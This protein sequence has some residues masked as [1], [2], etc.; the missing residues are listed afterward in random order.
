MI[1]A[2]THGSGQVEIEHEEPKSEEGRGK[3]E[4]RLLKIQALAALEKMH[5]KAKGIWLLITA[6]FTWKETARI[7]HVGEPTIRDVLAGKQI[8]AGKGEE[9]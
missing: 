1:M 6:G 9:E 4:D 2:K 3:Y 5:P 8:K 7:L